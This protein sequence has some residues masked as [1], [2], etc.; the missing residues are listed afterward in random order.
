MN[1]TKEITPDRLAI[2]T[3]EVD[4]DQ[5]QSAMKRAAQNISRVRPMP[6]FRPGKAPYE[7]V[8]RTFG[9]EVIAEEAIDELSRSLYRDVL[10]EN[11]LN[12][13]DAGS[14]EI[15]QKEPPIL[16]YTIP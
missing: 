13:I 10:K 5:M 11:D 7:M 4:E 1:I 14:L 15:V 6:G 8:E 16:K 2:V 3:V 9:K 12:P